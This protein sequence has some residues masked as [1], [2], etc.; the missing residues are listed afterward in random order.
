MCTRLDV[1]F[2][3]AGTG[4][5]GSGDME[6]LGRFKGGEV[7]GLA[8]GRTEAEAGRSTCCAWGPVAFLSRDESSR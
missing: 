6:A 3:N 8:D 4:R 7:D 5:G 1:G 2:D